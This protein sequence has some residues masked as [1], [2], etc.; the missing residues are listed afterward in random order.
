MHSPLNGIDHVVIVSD[1]LD[2][3]A[4]RYQALGFKLTPRGHHTMGTANHCAMFGDDYLEL[5][6]VPASAQVAPAMRAF[7][8]TAGPGLGAIAL[9]TD[10]AAQAREALLARGLDA[11][12]LRDFSRPVDL[13]GDTVQARFRT[14]DLPAGHTPGAHAFACQHYTREVA[15][16]PGYDEHPNGVTGLDAL[17]LV[18]REPQADLLRYAGLLGGDVEPDASAWRLRAPGASLLAI[19]PGSLDALAPGLPADARPLPYLAL[20][21]LTVQ[22]IARTQ[23]VLERNGVAFARQA[24]GDLLVAPALAQGVALVFAAGVSP[25]P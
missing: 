6:G 10:D 9:R 2:H 23:A 8:D 14:L 15:W 7:L 16:R 11:G 19:E 3:G 5:M 24:G 13:D 22:D 1:D 20:L 18:S 21:R 17:V 4:A 12:E 25:R